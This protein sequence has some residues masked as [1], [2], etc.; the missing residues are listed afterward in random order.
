M[1]NLGALLCKPGCRALTELFNNAA[2]F[3]M[4]AMTW[5]K[6]GIPAQ[7]S[8]API[9]RMRPLANTWISVGTYYGV[10]ILALSG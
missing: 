8:P 9:S 2:W 10:L 6:R 7:K 1:A 3:F 5:V 4:H